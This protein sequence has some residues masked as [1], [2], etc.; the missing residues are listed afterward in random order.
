LPYATFLFDWMAIVYGFRPRGVFAVAVMAMFFMHPS[1]VFATAPYAIY[2]IGTPAALGDFSLTL[3]RASIA[4]DSG[5]G[6]VV[7]VIAYTIQNI[8]PK[9]AS[10]ARFP[11][12]CLEDR[13]GAIY[14]AIATTKTVPEPDLSPGQTVTGTARFSVPSGLGDPM[15]LLLRL[16]GDQAPRVTLR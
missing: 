10:L 6:D 4:A 14:D 9:P 3:D 1:E 13:K 2:K 15:A 12:L 16:G 5:T 8:S 7:I 11:G